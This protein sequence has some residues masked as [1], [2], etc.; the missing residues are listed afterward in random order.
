M[1]SEGCVKG[2]DKV[3]LVRWWY[4]VVGFCAE[5]WRRLVTVERRL[6]FG[7]PVRDCD[8]F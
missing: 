1:S 4:L 8:E 3:S 6:L 2:L 5:R 7:D